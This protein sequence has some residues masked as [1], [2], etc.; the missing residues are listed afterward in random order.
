MI[1]ILATVFAALLGLAFGSF[2]NVCLSRW[3]EGESIVRPRSHCRHC[4]HALAWWEN[5]PVLSWLALRGRCRNCRASIGCRYLLV[6]VSIAALWAGIMWHALPGCLGVDCFPPP[7]HA[8]SNICFLVLLDGGKVVLCW[9][10]VA[11]AVLDAE[12]LWLPDWLTLPGAAFFEQRP[13]PV[14]SPERRSRSG[15]ESRR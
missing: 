3:P 1:R 11:L 12:H 10:L 4:D 8:V 7:D 5:V 9:L 13:R 14:P 6:E 15:L 2:L